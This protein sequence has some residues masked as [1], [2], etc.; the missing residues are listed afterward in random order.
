MNYQKTYISIN[1]YLN[2]ASRNSQRNGKA[3]LLTIGKAM[4]NKG[5]QKGDYCL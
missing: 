4:Q 3:K 1:K 2:F 5:R